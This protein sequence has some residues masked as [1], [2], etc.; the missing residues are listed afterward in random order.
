MLNELKTLHDSYLTQEVSED[1][2]AVDLVNEPRH[3]DRE[4]EQHVGDRQRGDE[5]VARSTKVCVEKDAE[6]DHQVAQDRE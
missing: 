2:F 1:P 4:A 6:H 3:H 5:V